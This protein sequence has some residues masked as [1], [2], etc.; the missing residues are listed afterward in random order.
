MITV[1]R[2]LSTSELLDRTFHLYKN[3]FV[4]FAV[5]TAI[6][7]IAGLALHMADAASPL[8]FAAASRGLRTLFFVAVAYLGMEVSHS[9]TAVAVSK[10]HLGGSTSIRSAYS[11]AKRS[12]LRVIWILFITFLLPLALSVALGVLAMGAT[13]GVL[14]SM[15]F[16]NGGDKLTNV[17]SVFSLVF[18]FLAVPLLALRLYLAWSLAVPVTVLEGGGLRATMR[19]S[20]RLT[21]GR[22][23]RI[24]AV[25][26][27]VFL[28][29]YAVRI[30]F[31]IPYYVLSGGVLRHPHGGNTALIVSAVLAF[32]STSLV[33]P[34][35]EIAFTLIYYD[36]R[37]RKEGF[38]L[39]LMMSNLEGGAPAAAAVAVS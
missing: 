6:P 13:A 23:G 21:A 5:I 37:V 25:Y 35:L 3:N 18:I 1:L 28:L 22:R 10:L 14:D 31:Q 36:E 30:L 33:G 8:L 29:S 32:L 2:P 27:L 38:D 24:F 19:R 17:A 4:L 39:Q 20:R 34:I 11:S 16:L 9:A 12:I 15:G 26:L 7:Q